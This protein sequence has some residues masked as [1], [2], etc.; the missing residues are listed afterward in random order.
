MNL[1][2]LTRYLENITCSTIICWMNELVAFVLF[3][4][5]LVRKE[6]QHALEVNM[7]IATD[8]RVPRKGQKQSVA[9]PYILSFP[10]RISVIPMQW[11]VVCFLCSTSQFLYRTINRTWVWLQHFLNGI[12]GNSDLEWCCKSVLIVWVD[13]ES[14][15]ML[16]IRGT[17]ERNLR[18]S[19]SITGANPDLM[20]LLEQ[21]HILLPFG[22]RQGH[23]HQ[24]LSVSFSCISVPHPFFS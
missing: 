5:D 9:T 22:E 19:A 8:A 4:L 20:W 17:R 14:M 24:C 3:V 2:R 18:G 10:L 13:S 6:N 1:Q 23:V 21:T 15:K 11:S 7:V 12:L 16:Y